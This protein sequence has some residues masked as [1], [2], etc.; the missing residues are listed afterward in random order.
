M[1]R[2]FSNN[3]HEDFMTR[4]IELAYNGLG[5]VSPNPLVGCIIVKDGEIIGE[6]YHKEFGCNHAEVEA[7]IN[8]TKSP[9]GSTLY[10]T[11]EPCCI[12]GKTPPCTDYLIQNGIRT[13]YVGS[14][15][16]NPKVNGNGV[17]ILKS[18]GI[19]VVIGILKQECEELNKGY[20]KWQRSK[21]PWV[22]VKIAESMD[23][24]ISKDSNSQTFI[25]EE[26]AL[27]HSHKLRSSVDAILVGRQTAM[28]DNPR[29]TVRKVRGPNPTRVILDT[30]RV[31][32]L[33][34][35]IFTDKDAKTIVI[36]S[37]ERFTNTR[38]SHR[39]YLVCNEDTNGL[40]DTSMILEILGS[41]GITTLLIEGGA[42]TIS[43]FIKND[44]VDEVYL[45][46]SQ[47]KEINGILKTPIDLD[48]GWDIF[49][50]LILGNDNLAI[51]RKKD[52][53]LQE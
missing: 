12:E 50:R 33:D 39:E 41:I 25:T 43:S 8:S 52:L 46:T 6:G 37:N 20:I 48:D 13:V 16:P 27:S 44:L 36:C 4:A 31:L 51:A 17:D 19:E 29:L 30:N 45:Y 11:L 22:I 28:V 10:V 7:C 23:G 49:D 24:F 2:I 47:I 15:D 14:L 40:L 42:K 3:V 38:V 53:C 21:K 1:D 9:E 34:L 18:A 32:P 35:N 26:E 5:S